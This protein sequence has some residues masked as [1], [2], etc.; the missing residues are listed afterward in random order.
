MMIIIIIIIIIIK[1]LIIIT[2]IV[3]G[4]ESISIIILRQ[5]SIFY[6][7]THYTHMQWDCTAVRM[8][9][10]LILT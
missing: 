4:N 9:V 7:L 3:K 2:L 5:R 8:N 10:K 1:T 6:A